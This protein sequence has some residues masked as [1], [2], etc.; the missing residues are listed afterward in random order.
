MEDKVLGLPFPNPF[1]DMEAERS[2]TG[3]SSDAANDDQSAMEDFINDEEYNLL[4][5]LSDV[6]LPPPRKNVSRRKPA[7]ESE[8]ESEKDELQDTPARIGGRLLIDSDQSTFDV[9]KLLLMN[10]EL[11]NVNN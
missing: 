4:S 5:N 9:A 2:G 7:H 6:I 10:D 3:H 8:S 11:L 1:V